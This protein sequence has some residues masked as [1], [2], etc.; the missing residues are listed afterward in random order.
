MGHPVFGN[1]LVKLSENRL[2]SFLQVLNHVR[3][4]KSQGSPRLKPV[5]LRSIYNE[6]AASLSEI[7]KSAFIVPVISNSNLAGK[8]QREVEKKIQQIRSSLGRI[9]GS[10]DKLS[11]ELSKIN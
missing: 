10:P 8:L 1:L 7:W 11:A 4:L 5:E 6:V 9:I 3:Y 2:P